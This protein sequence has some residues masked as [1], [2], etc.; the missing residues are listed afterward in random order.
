M[1]FKTKN[2]LAIIKQQENNLLNQGNQ[3]I[4][5]FRHKNKFKLVKHKTSRWNIIVMF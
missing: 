3:I 2:I 4:S 1:S 5:R